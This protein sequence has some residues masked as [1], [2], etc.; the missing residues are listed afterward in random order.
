M[1]TCF[2][3]FCNVERALAIIDEAGNAHVASVVSRMEEKIKR[4]K[5]AEAEVTQLYTV[6][7]SSR[8]K[9]ELA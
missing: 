9:R 7:A 6:F 4:D 3:A 1:I 2:F 8:I 5:E